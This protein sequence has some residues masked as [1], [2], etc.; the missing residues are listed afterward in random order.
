MDRSSIF[1]VLICYNRK[2]V[3]H[4]RTFFNYPWAWFRVIKKKDD[5]SCKKDNVRA[6]RLRKSL[7]NRE[8]TGCF[9]VGLAILEQMNRVS[10]NNIVF[11][12]GQSA[13][14]SEPG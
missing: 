12:D 8:C 2:Q 9:F 4:S 3:A 5:F 6:A 11:G 7:K 13:Y 14:T 1:L 10:I